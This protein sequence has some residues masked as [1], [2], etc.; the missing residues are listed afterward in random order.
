[1]LS[2]ESG[3]RPKAVTALW[4][5]TPT[6]IFES[7]NL[8]EFVVR[9][10]KALRIWVNR[11]SMSQDDENTWVKPRFQ[12]WVLVGRSCTQ[13]ASSGPLLTPRCG[14]LLNKYRNDRRCLSVME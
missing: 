13:V 14:T 9:T 12:L 2:C 6:P 7:E 5:L 1:M 3:L 8:G 11:A 10:P 4:S